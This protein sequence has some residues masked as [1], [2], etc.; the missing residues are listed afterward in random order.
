MASPFLFFSCGFRSLAGHA[1]ATAEQCA[2][3]GWKMARYGHKDATWSQE[4]GQQRCNNSSNGRGAGE[5]NKGEAAAGVDK[6]RLLCELLQQL[7]YLQVT[8]ESMRASGPACKTP[9]RCC[10]L[11]PLGRQKQGGRWRRAPGLGKSLA[12]LALLWGLLGQHDSTNEHSRARSWPVGLDFRSHASS[13][14]QGRGSRGVKIMRT[15]EVGKWS[16]WRQGGLEVACAG[17]R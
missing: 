16:W 13:R 15:A 3:P 2:P 1:K 17:G 6:N 4:G 7:S 5:S 14:L 12:R 9:I 11:V 8:N 10:H